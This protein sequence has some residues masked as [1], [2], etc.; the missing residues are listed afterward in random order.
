MTRFVLGPGEGIPVHDVEGLEL[1]VIVPSGFDVG[2]ANWDT[3]ATPAAVPTNE[4]ESVHAKV[5]R[6]GHAL[7]YSKTSAPPVRN[8]GR[9]PLDLVSVALQPTGGL[10]CAVSPVDT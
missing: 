1:L 6:S 2:T 5:Q 4:D 9:F 8:V 10:S 3:G 7:V